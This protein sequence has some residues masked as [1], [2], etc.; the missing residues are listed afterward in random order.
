[1]LSGDR[2]AARRR[3]APGPGPAPP[4]PVLIHTAAD[5]GCGVTCR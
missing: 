5:V 4:G 3:A 2:A 1:V